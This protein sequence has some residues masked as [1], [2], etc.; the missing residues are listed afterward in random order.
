V[1]GAPWGIPAHR[2]GALPGSER[3]TVNDVGES[4]A[5][6]PHVRFDRGPPARRPPM[7]RRKP[8]TQRETGGTKPYPTYRRARNQRLGK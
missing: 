8:S 4:Y 3:L 7:A 1:A 2:D 6:E 5:G